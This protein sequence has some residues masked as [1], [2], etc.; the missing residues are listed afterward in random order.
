MN[1]DLKVEL[2]GLLSTIQIGD[3]WAERLKNGAFMEFLSTHLS[4]GYIEVR[5]I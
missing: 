1:D 2:I 4:L 3:E 5:S